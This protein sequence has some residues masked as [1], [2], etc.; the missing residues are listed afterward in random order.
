VTV[1]VF[2]LVACG[3]F[4]GSGLRTPDDVETSDDT[5][6]RTV[7]TELT[8]TGDTGEPWPAAT[9]SCAAADAE[10]R[11][12]TERPETGDTLTVEVSADTGYV[13]IGM[14][15]DGYADSLGGVEISGSGP[16]TWTY[17]YRVTGPGWLVFT[18]TADEGATPICEGEVFA[19]GEIEEPPP[20]TGTTDPGLP[21]DN[22]VGIGLVGP[23]N[24]DQWD[25]AAELSGPGGHIKLIFPGMVPG[26]SGAP[27]EW[28]E[29]VRQVQARDLV[30]VIRL[31]PPW[32]ETDIRHW[33]DDAAHRS[34]TGYAASFAA[35]VSD[36][37]LREGWPLWLEVLNEP[38]LCYEWTCDGSDRSSLDYETIAAE[39][40]SLLRDVTSHRGRR[41]QRPPGRCRWPGRTGRGG[42]PG[43]GRT[44]RGPAASDRPLWSPCPRRSTS[45]SCSGPGRRA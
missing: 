34:Y 30:P 44:S 15:V 24:E 8:D 19:K 12:S 2:L 22:P 11:F 37:P 25:R 23:G 42:R 41:S 3:S 5:G 9:T 28:I 21:P 4:S 31:N 43:P 35:V 26:M 27:A 32:G 1:L 17:G 38:N 7:D 39:Y 13:W 45:R 29:A 36:L 20:D 18:F 16:Y 40:A 14:E 33:S 10:L 6:S